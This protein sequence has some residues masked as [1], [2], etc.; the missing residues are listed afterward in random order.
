M[1]RHIVFVRWK[2][3][4]TEDQKQA[5]VDGLRELPALIPEIKRYDLGRD[6]GLAPG[7]H[8]FALVADF[9]SEA[10]FKT[11]AEH[12]EHLRVIHGAIK[13][14]ISERAAVQLLLDDD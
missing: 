6:A 13:P 10:D 11:Y 2:A 8:D 7:N 4:A 9:A 12:P 1:L 14:A 3:D 5:V